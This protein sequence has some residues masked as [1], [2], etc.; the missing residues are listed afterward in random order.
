M[1]IVNLLISLNMFFFTINATSFPLYFCRMTDTLDPDKNIFESRVSSDLCVSA[2]NAKSNCK[3]HYGS[4]HLNCA[5]AW[6]SMECVELSNTN[7]S[8]KNIPCS[9]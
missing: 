1:K 4:D 6:N 8:I 5:V 2:R 3:A 7:Q 9:P